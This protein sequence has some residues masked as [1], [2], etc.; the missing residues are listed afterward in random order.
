MKMGDYLN[1]IAWFIVT[2]EFSFW[3]VILLGLYIRYS[4]G[5]KSLELIFLALT[6]L[7]DLALNVLTTLD[8]ARGS[9]ST[10]AQC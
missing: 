10:V 6:S 5:K 2:C 1:T 8:L 3:I 4:L 7:I 9:T